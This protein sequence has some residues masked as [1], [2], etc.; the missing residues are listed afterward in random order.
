M[1]ETSGEDP[2]KACGKLKNRRNQLAE[3][4]GGGVLKYKILLSGRKK[5]SRNAQN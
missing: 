4:S 1:R 5:L 2:E 3:T